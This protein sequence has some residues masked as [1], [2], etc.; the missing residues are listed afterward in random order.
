ML[1]YIC[2]KFH[3]NISKTVFELQSGH[4]FVTDRW[5]D[6]QT[7]WA[8][9]I[10]LRTLNGGDITIHTIEYSSKCDYSIAKKKINVKS[11]NDIPSEFLR[12]F[13]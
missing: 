12:K 2:V 1:V 8:K 4:N 9:T 3:E 7:T 10:C 11:P 5:T 13:L 6:G